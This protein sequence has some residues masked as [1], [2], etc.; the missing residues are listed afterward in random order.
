MY[1]SYKLFILNIK[2]VQMISASKK[3]IIITIILVLSFFL[4]QTIFIQGY[5][6]ST[7]D[8]KNKIASEFFYENNK[9]KRRSLYGY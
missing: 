2:E 8:Q 7:S 5:K 6:N 1:N 9:H 3:N 4:I